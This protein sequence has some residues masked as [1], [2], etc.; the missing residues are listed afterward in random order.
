SSSDRTMAPRRTAYVAATMKVEQD[1]IGKNRLGRRQP[2]SAH[3]AIDLFDLHSARLS[4]A[5][6][7]WLSEEP[8]CATN[9]GS[10][11]IYRPVLDDGPNHGHSDASAKAGHF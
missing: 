2:F 5:E 11:V 9:H 6:K 4:K 8:A 1:R 7:F 10:A 3:L